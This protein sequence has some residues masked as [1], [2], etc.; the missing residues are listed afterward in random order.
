MWLAGSGSWSGRYVVAKAA[1]IV[2]FKNA[3]GRTALHLAFSVGNG[4]MA[5]AL[6]EAGAGLHSSIHVRTMASGR[7]MASGRKWRHQP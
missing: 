5:Q 6:L 4:P 1:P 2:D 3:K 7:A